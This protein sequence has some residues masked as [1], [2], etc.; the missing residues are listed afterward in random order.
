MSLGNLP[1]KASNCTN[2]TRFDFAEISL[3]SSL[4]WDDSQTDLAHLGGVAPGAVKSE[5]G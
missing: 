3:P 4:D 5:G 2:S 1:S